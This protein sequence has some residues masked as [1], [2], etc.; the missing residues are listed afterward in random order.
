MSQII[1]SLRCIKAGRLLSLHV[2]FL[3]I[4]QSAVQ[5]RDTD[6]FNN[7][8]I[9]IVHTQSRNGIGRPYTTIYAT[10]MLS[11]TEKT[12][13]SRI[14]EPNTKEKR[15]STIKKQEIFHNK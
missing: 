1:F 10:G 14:T 15:Y 6:I 11:S 9:I 2:H 5:K 12:N 4:P 8:I 7:I 3:L 13:K